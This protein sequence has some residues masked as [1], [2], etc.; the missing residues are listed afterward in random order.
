MSFC[1]P[2]EDRNS[3]T[4]RFDEAAYA[5][6][7]LA[8][9][10]HRC[11]QESLRFFQQIHSNDWFCYDLFRRAIVER[12]EAAWHY[13]YL[14][15]EPL[16]KGWA[17]RHPQFALSEEDAFF[18]ANRAFEKM[19]NAVSGERFR[20][21]PDLKALLRYLKLCV[22]AVIIDHIRAQKEPHVSLPA[23]GTITIDT[24]IEE[25]LLHEE[26]WRMIDE[27][28]NDDKERLA[29]Y[30][31]Y[32]AGMMPREIQAEYSA[33]FAEVSD[34]HRILQNVLARLRRDSE[35]QNFFAENS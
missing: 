25:R 26:L 17:E 3:T 14:Q 7:S 9:I 2:P 23:N 21:F 8:G 12:K 19:W 18:F 28:L 10:V 5:R 35:L 32:N 30:C 20:H 33:I 4:N 6:I 31:R 27:R 24:P 15:Y 13:I 1:P 11:K 22:N 29:I 34:V 16:V